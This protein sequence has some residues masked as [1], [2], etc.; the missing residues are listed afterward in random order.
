MGGCC[1]AQQNYCEI[2]EVEDLERGILSQGVLSS[3]N[4]YIPPLYNPIVARGSAG[5]KSTQGV[6]WEVNRW[7]IAFRS[8]TSSF[9]LRGDQ[10]QRKTSSGKSSGILSSG[11]W[12]LCVT[13]FFCMIYLWL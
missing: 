1:R 10:H 11:E 2:G 12:Y 9:K 6:G 4:Y 7:V 8:S 3:T 13:I 5:K